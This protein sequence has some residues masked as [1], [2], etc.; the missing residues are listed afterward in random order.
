[1]EI[2]DLEVLRRNLTEWAPTVVGAILTLIIG[3]WL[4]GW[5][6]GLV[7]KALKRSQ[8]DQTIRPFLSSLVSVGLKVLLLITVAGMFGI[9]TT[10]IIAMFGAL[11]FAVGLALQG[12]LGHFASGVLIL[13]FK[14]YKVGDLVKIGGGETGSVEEI[15]VFHTILK[16]LDNKKIIIPNGVVTDNVITNISGQGIIG[17]ELTFGIGYGDDIDKARD[18]ILRVGKECPTILDEPAQAVVVAELADSSVNLAT[19]P[20][21]DSSDYWATYF[22]MQENV[23]KAFDAEGV[24]IPFPQ[25]D[26]HMDQ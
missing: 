11:A 14:P 12:S 19:R 26:V 4:I 9:E 15:Q 3:F 22:Y 1:M 13:V 16:T 24:S 25:V 6:T 7:K 5:I 17:V 10:S 23:K 2:F 20:F 21:C 8:I 18:I